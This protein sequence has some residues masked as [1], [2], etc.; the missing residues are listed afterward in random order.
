MAIELII[1]ITFIFIFIRLQFSVGIQKFIR[2]VI[3]ADILTG[4]KKSLSVA[5]CFIEQILTGL[6]YKNSW[7]INFT[8]KIW[9]GLNKFLKVDS[10][11]YNYSEIL[12]SCLGAINI[13]LT[14]FNRQTCCY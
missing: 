8:F 3:W 12:D 11:Y 6:K 14:T 5:G 2:V 7:K 13:Q 9:S 10:G 1:N 4:I